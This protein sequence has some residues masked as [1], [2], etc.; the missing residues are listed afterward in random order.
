MIHARRRAERKSL[1]LKTHHPNAEVTFRW[2]ALTNRNRKSA[3]WSW[4]SQFQVKG[5]RMGSAESKVLA[6]TPPS[7]MRNKRL[8]NVED[9]RSPSTGISRTPIQ[10]KNVSTP[11]TS[12][13]AT[14]SVDPQES[15]DPRSPSVGIT[16]TP[17]KALLA[18]TMTLLVRQLNEL[19]V[20]EGGE[21]ETENQGLEGGARGTGAEESPPVLSPLGSDEATHPL[22]VKEAVS[23]SPL[24]GVTPLLD[25]TSL[26]SPEEQPSKVS[27]LIGPNKAKHSGNHVMGSLGQAGVAVTRLPQGKVRGSGRLRPRRIKSSVLSSSEDG[28]RSPLQILQHLDWNSPHGPQHSQMKKVLSLLDQDGV[29]LKCALSRGLHRDKENLESWGS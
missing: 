5:Y 26:L 14:L 13:Y 15:F 25:P 2:A 9:P 12:L 24:T 10:M 4:S 1:L 28:S 20:S 17:V 19:F 3:R 6:D 8:E 16:R 22:T 21:L 23:E 18:E 7:A 11:S 29:T 27:A